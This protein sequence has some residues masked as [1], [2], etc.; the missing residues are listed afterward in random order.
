VSILRLRKRL[1]DERGVVAVFV[2]LLLIVLLGSA[3]IMFDIARLRHERH[4]LQAAVDL[5]SLAGAGYMPVQGATAGTIAR[6]S[7]RAIA[8]ANAPSLAA[9]GLTIEFGCVVSDPNN[10]G[11]ADSPDL[12]FACG[13]STSGTWTG[14]W[15]SQ[16]GR[17]Y[18]VC[19]PFGGDLCNTIKLVAISSVDYF[20]APVLGFDQGSTGAVR[21]A[22][23]KGFCGQASSPLDV[24]LVVDRSTSMTV[25]DVQNLK[26]A[27]ANTTPASDSILEF[28]DPADVQIGL[29]GLPYHRTTPTVNK[30]VTQPD[31]VYPNNPNA[32]GDRW[33]LVDIMAG[34][35][36]ADKT[37]NTS[38]ELVSTVLC[39]QRANVTS[40]VPAG[41]GHTNHGDPLQ[42]ASNML[43][44]SRAD[45]PDVIVYF[46]D[47]EAN[48]PR[49]SQPC[50]YANTRATTAKTTRNILIFT[51]A[52]GAAGARCGFDTA[53]SPFGPPPSGGDFATTFLSAMASEEQ[54]GV[55]SDDN[56]PGGCDTT[57]PTTENN[58]GDFYFCE[59]R[60]TDLEATFRRIAVQSVQR[61][62]L[63]NF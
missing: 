43:A 49:N 7:A 51:L 34:Y 53:G 41:A 1:D 11:G 18:H 17:A 31:Q 63:L 9:A 27:I 20:F 29:V 35:Q 19:N 16:S 40:T 21:A 44:A 36:N 15:T 58:D 45:V 6:D 10:N 56:F 14:G 28:Y 24:V 26:D 2:A 55:A 8:V 33:K 60:G 5:G 4:I 47:G 42:A 13:P 61:T 22:A 25:A 37:L 23:C 52:Y 30:C 46:A 48:Q 3:A 59:S 12:L 57:L 38:N 62:R 39:L 32:A 50:Q 54:P